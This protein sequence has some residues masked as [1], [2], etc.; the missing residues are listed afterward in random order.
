MVAVTPRKGSVSSCSG[1]GRANGAIETRAAASRIVAAEVVTS[2]LG[3]R[4]SE[5]KVP[6]P[7]KRGSANEFRSRWEN[8]R[9]KGI[10]ALLDASPTSG[11]CGKGEGTADDVAIPVGIW[12]CGGADLV[13]GSMLAC[14]NASLSV[15]TSALLDTQECFGELG[16]G[17]SHISSPSVVL[18]GAREDEASVGG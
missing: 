6:F 5:F 15:C 12:Y 10:V 14:F 18:E 16:A 9:F 3:R 11:S 17:E 8:P 4:E 7:E 2:V 13:K 1:E